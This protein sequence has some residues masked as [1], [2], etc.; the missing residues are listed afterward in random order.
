VKRAFF[1]I[2]AEH[3]A[4]PDLLLIYRFD[5][6]SQPSLADKLYAG[7][8]SDGIAF[9]KKTFNAFSLLQANEIILSSFNEL[10]VAVAAEIVLLAR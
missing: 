6:S 1:L 5:E 10:S 4:L 8:A 2:L 3:N 9:Q 7:D